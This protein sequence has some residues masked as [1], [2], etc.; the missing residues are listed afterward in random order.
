MNT[1]RF[2]NLKL[3]SAVSIY[4]FCALLSCTNSSFD[5]FMLPTPEVTDAPSTEASDIEIS[6]DNIADGITPARVTLTLRTAK[7][8]PIVGMTPAIAVSGTQNIVVPCTTSDANGTS[9]CWLYTTRAELK[10]ISIVG[11]VSM[12][13]EVSFTQPVPLKSN[14]AFVSSASDVTAVSGHRIISTSG[15]IESDFVQKDS[16]GK[17]RLRSSVL[18]SVIN[19]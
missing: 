11:V 15:I 1:K 7:R 6:G 2:I 18:S 13:K 14:F 10:T 4:A 16:T 3:L 12:S 8:L 9:H 19:D 17:I 5:A